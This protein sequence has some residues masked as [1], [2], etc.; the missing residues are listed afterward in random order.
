VH[1]QGI[2]DL[3][4]DFIVEARA[5]DGVIEAVRHGG[6]GYVAAVQWHPEFHVGDNAHLLAGAPLLADFLAA[7]RAAG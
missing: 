5:P 4:P 7:C 2:K 1:H 3:A 6:N